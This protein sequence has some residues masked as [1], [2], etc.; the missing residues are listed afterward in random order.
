MRH[1]SLYL[2]VVTVQGRPAPGI[3]K[4]F[5]LATDPACMQDLHLFAE[6][7]DKSIS[8]HTTQRYT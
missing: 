7:T 1:T 4:A 5:R 8:V 2:Y 6:A 3:F